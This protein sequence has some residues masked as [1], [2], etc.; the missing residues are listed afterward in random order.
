MIDFKQLSVLAGI[1]AVASAPALASGASLAPTTQ[2]TVTSGPADAAGLDIAG[3][4]EVDDDDKTLLGPNNLTA[5]QLDDMDVVTASGDKIGEIDE[6]LADA[7][8]QVVAVTVE[9]GGFLGMG[10]KEV[11]VGFDRLTL[12]GDRFTTTLSSDDLKSLPE[13]KK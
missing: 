13:W 12:Q 10:K 9:M 3:L 6:V 8:G 2:T 11:V 1:L 7:S 5:D 4:R